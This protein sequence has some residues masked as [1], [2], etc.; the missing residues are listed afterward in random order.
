MTQVALIAIPSRKH[1]QHCSIMHLR[2]SHASTGYVVQNPLA[3]RLRP[4]L[5]AR[6]QRPVPSYRLEDCQ[7]LSYPFS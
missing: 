6:S 2:L 3:V 1:V 5:R 7:R 4:Q